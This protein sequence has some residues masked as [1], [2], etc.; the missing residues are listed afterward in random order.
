MRILF[1][2]IFSLL[3]SSNAFAI[4]CSLP[5]C[6]KFKQRQ[7]A[8]FAEMDA[9]KYKI[10]KASFV[11]PTPFKKRTPKRKAILLWPLK[12]GKISSKFGYRKDPFSGHRKHHNGLDLAAPIGTRIRA[13]ASGVVIKSGWYRNGC[14]IGVTIDHGKFKTYYCHASKVFVQPGDRIK[15]GQSIGRV[16]STGHSTGPHLHFEVHKDNKAYDPL[17]L[18]G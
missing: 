12:R 5:L 8:M 2:M 4:E 13:A 1:I 14:G 18:L 16:G 15:R 10:R 9:F 11:R 7:S 6:L 17:K 3:M